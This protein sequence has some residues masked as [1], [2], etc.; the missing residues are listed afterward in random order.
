MLSMMVVLMLLYVFMTYVSEI[1][2][3]GEVL[4]YNASNTAPDIIQC[5]N[6]S[7]DCI[8]NCIG[9]EICEHKEIHCHNKS[10]TSICKINFNGTRNASNAVIYTHTSPIVFINAIGDDACLQSVIYGHETINTKL[11]V[12]APSIR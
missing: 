10:T 5:L 7:S 11:Y 8:I 1:M 6:P 3:K 12:Y 9:D 2:T 4:V